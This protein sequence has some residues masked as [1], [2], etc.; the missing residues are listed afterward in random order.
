[1]MEL[2]LSV[3]INEDQEDIIT[4]HQAK[5]TRLPKYIAT[6]PAPSKSE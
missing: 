1:M 2:V 5:K 4:P 6:V 3:K